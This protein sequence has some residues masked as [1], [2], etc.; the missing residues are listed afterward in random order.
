MM[1]YPENVSVTYGDS[2]LTKMSKTFAAANT[3]G[4]LEMIGAGGLVGGGGTITA[5]SV[6]TLTGV[7]APVGAAAVEF[8]EGMVL[9]GEIVGGAGVLCDKLGLGGT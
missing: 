3:C 7:G 5:G 1:T 9:G 2:A 8:G 6:M 4:K